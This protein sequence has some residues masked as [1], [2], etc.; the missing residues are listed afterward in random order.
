MCDKSKWTSYNLIKLFIKDIQDS[1]CKNEIKSI[2]LEYINGEVL[3]KD[4]EDKINR[5]PKLARKVL[6]YD[7]RFIEKEL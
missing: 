4:L 7:T 3:T 5:S 6:D 2:E 1:F